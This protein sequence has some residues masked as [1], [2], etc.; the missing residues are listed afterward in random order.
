ML[1]YSE[2]R[3]QSF[4]VILVT[5][6]G[7]LSGVWDF[8]GGTQCKTMQ[9]VAATWVEEPPL[10]MLTLTLALSSLSPKRLPKSGHQF[11]DNKVLQLEE[12]CMWE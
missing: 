12:S 11:L 4:E 1:K 2:P 3:G 5:S 6:T 8:K 7:Q 10:I 9:T